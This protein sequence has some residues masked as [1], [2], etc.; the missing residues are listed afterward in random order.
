MTGAETM[1]MMRHL[2]HARYDPSG[3]YVILVA[4]ST[5]PAV[6]VPRGLSDLSVWDIQATRRICFLK[7][8]SYITGISFGPRDGQFMAAHG[9]GSITL[10][11]IQ[12]GKVLH[13]LR[14]D[15]GRPAALLSI[16]HQTGSKWI[17]AGSLDGAL[18]VWDVAERKLQGALQGEEGYWS[19]VGMN[20]DGSLV[21]QI[22]SGNARLWDPGSLKEISS[23]KASEGEGPI[24]FD[25]KCSRLAVAGSNGSIR[26]LEPGNAKVTLHLE[27]PG[28]KIVSLRFSAIGE[29]IASGAMDGEVR[30][31]S[32]KTGRCLRTLRAHK[33]P[34]TGLTFSADGTILVTHGFKEKT[35]RVWNSGSG[36]ETRDIDSNAQSSTVD[37]SPD[38]KFIV[39]VTSD[40]KAD[41]IELSTGH[42]L[43][44]LEH[45]DPVKQFLNG[46]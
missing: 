45:E 33:G 32:T 7:D 6:D 27:G 2:A 16:A 17:V 4:S 42:K 31:W 3:R 44:T 26:L 18:S 36:A 8:I 13:T 43:A 14:G 38:S 30:L 28:S 40:L 11:D 46:E 19:R 37:I 15:E 20:L 5:I 1:R 39:V 10:R 21:Y 12:S 41:H 22:N 24:E 34:V 23:F 9:D 25:H 29:I 35:I